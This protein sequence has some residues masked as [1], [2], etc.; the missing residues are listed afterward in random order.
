MH[1][2]VYK[3]EAKTAVNLLISAAQT[4]QK[5]PNAKVSFPENIRWYLKDDASFEILCNLEEFLPKDVK[6]FISQVRK[7]QRQHPEMVPF[8]HYIRC[9]SN[10]LSLDL[11]QKCLLS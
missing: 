6:C 8:E 11:L 3:E 7:T 10:S 2:E 1:E 4:L 9:N 5:N